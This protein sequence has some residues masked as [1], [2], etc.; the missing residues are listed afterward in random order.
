MNWETIEQK[1]KYSIDLTEEEIKWLLELQNPSELK[2]LYALANQVNE[3]LNGRAV[4][5]IHNMN[6]NYTNI[7][8]Y[9]CTFCE[10]KKSSISKDAYVLSFED[11]KQR[12]GASDGTLSEITFQGGLSSEVKFQEVLGLLKH[13]RYGG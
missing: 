2:R 7:C 11:V 13:V 8:E 12:I 6:V 10:F 3:R 1:E 4:S 5:F 9:H